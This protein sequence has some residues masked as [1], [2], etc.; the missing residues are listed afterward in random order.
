MNQIKV[1]GTGN[2]TIVPMDVFTS[3]EFN[4][5]A[6]AI[7]AIVKAATYMLAL[8]KLEKTQVKYAEYVLFGTLVPYAIDIDPTLLN[9]T[10]TCFKISLTSI[11]LITIK[12]WLVLKH[13]HCEQNA[14]D[15]KFNQESFYY[16]K[17]LILSIREILITRPTV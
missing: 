6:K 11:E 10:E 5:T 14:D 1:V 7:L 12:D 9:N 3:G 16:M 2:Y 17:D 8:K 4:F 13:D 15:A